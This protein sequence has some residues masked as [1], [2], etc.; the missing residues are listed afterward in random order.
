MKAL[1]PDESNPI[2]TLHG[3]S[4]SVSNALAKMVSQKSSRRCAGSEK[5]NRDI[6]LL[7][8]F[9]VNCVCAT[10]AHANPCEMIRQTI[11]TFASACVRSLDALGGHVSTPDGELATYASARSRTE[12]YVNVRGTWPDS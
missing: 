1:L 12:S 7:A 10:L 8:P 9:P 2:S 4:I 6:L 11:A 5:R 3:V